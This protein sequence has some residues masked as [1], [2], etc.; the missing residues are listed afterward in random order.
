VVDR[1]LSVIHSKFAR[2][3]AA[4]ALTA[5]V[6]VACAPPPPLNTPMLHRTT[7]VGALDHP[8]DIAFTPDNTM[9]FT[10]RPGQLNARLTNGTVIELAFMPGSTSEPPDLLLGSEGGM[11]GLAVDPLFASS[12][13]VY[14]CYTSSAPG[15]SGDVRVVRWVI[16]GTYTQ[17]SSP[18]PVVTGM[19]RSSGR[20]S[21]CR[22]RF[23]P[24]TKHLYISTGDAAEGTN[25]QDLN[26]LGGKLLRVNRNGKP[27]DDNPFVGVAGD[28]RIYNYGHRNVQGL[29]FRPGT[30]VPFTVEHGTGCD[31]EVNIGL[32]GANYGWDP[33]P[34]YNEST[35]MTDL[36]KFPNAIPAA[37][38]SG[39]PTIAPSGAT[40][41]AGPQWEGWRGFLVVAVLKDHYL[42]IFRVSGD[43]LV[44]TPV[45][46]RFRSMNARLRSAV[47][48]PDG[49]LYIATDVGPGGEIWKITPS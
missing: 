44:A 42:Q 48:G 27:I 22:P 47:Q 11:L 3:A 38:K 24:G 33:V 28:D 32:K 21:G 31:D 10:E 45:A 1:V 13:F 19:P 34:G 20:H 30:K 26:S 37:W 39:C 49:N 2:I 23:K 40:F 46:Q 14:T 9:L 18:M 41:L 43:G 12:G 35:P 4:L 5:L 15:G 16:N 6:A 8:W 7:L 17:A 29:A 25:P 36:T